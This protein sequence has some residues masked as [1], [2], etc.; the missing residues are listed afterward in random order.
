MSVVNKNK[1]EYYYDIFLEK[2]LYKNKS[3]TQNF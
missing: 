3:N 1:N 2:G